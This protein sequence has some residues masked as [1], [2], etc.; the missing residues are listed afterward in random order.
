[1]VTSSDYDLNSIPTVTD[2]LTNTRE[3][4]LDSLQFKVSMLSLSN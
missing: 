2:C 3:R 4:K 1:M